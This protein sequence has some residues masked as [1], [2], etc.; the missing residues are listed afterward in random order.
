MK[1]PSSLKSSLSSQGSLCLPHGESHPVETPSFLV[2]FYLW[3]DFNFRHDSAWS[4]GIFLLLILGKYAYITG[5][6]NPFNLANIQILLTF[7]G[8]AI[9]GAMGFSRVL[10]FF[11]NI[12]VLRPR[13]LTGILVGSMKKVRLGKLPLKQS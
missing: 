11:R 7:L 12:I 2:Y 5:R 10:N 13:P 9:L 6:K 1:K 4:F 8:G 3:H